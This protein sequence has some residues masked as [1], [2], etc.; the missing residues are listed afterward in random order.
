GVSANTSDSRGVPAIVW[1]AF[2]GDAETI[3]ALLSAKANVRDPKLQAHTTL[4][5]YLTQGMM[6]EAYLPGRSGGKQITQE[7]RLAIHDQTVRLLIEAGAEVN[8]T[9]S[10]KELVLNRS[11][12]LVPNLLSLDTVKML[13]ARHAAVNDSDANGQTP[14]M[15]A[16]RTTSADLVRVLL[17]VGAKPTINARDKSGRSALMNASECFFDSGLKTV[18]LL[19][20]GGATINDSDASGATALMLAGKSGS[21]ATVKVL[22][23][24]GAVTSINSKDNKGK[25]A[26]I[27]SILGHGYFASNWVPTEVVKALVAAGAD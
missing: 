1:A 25:T 5:T 21:N 9:G 27:H 16:A 8:S 7:E 24:A 22:L 3:D 2:T 23:E 6:R 10:S 17:D 20:A 14:L 13:I 18:R 12:I 15:L 19:L 11:I 26:L 4:V